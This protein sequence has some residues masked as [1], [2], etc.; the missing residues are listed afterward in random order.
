MDRARISQ[1]IPRWDTPPGEIVRSWQQ[2]VDLLAELLDV[3]SVIVTRIHRGSAR[4]LVSSDS[5]GNPFPVGER[6]SGVTPRG[7]RAIRTTPPASWEPDAPSGPVWQRIQAQHNAGMQG[8]LG[9]MLRWPDGALFGSLCAL[10]RRPRLD[11]PVQQRLLQQF[12]RLLASDLTLLHAR[13]Q[14]EH[15]EN[16][17]RAQARTDALTGSLN[18]AAFDEAVDQAVAHARSSRRPLSLI[19]YDMDHF[20]QIN[21]AYGHATGDRALRESTRCVRELLRRDDDVFRIG[22]EEFVVL[23]PETDIETACDV[24][25]RIRRG[26]ASCDIQPGAALSV[27]LGV[28]EYLPNEAPGD[29]LRRLDRHLYAAKNAGRNCVWSQPPHC[30]AC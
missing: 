10:D 19:M 28:A 4:V 7:K 21:D 18:R 1:E 27:S 3:P 23:L 17:L 12:G 14:L 15:R 26:V 11:G 29:C 5:R 16:V 22:G 9:M 8:Y 13:C 2:P 30:T 20:K 6:S 25:E 24:A